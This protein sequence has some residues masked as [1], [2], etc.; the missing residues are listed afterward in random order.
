MELLNQE[1]I[2][3]NEILLLD[4]DTTSEAKKTDPFNDRN[5][6]TIQRSEKSETESDSEEEEDTLDFA[7]DIIT[8]SERDKDDLG[9]TPPAK[10][11]IFTANAGLVLLH[12]FLGILQQKKIGH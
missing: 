12:P 7:E 5:E 1:G 4:D 8:S 2:S 11:E 9:D 6:I 3:I 10:E